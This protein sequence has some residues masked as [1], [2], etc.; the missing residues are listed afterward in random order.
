MEVGLEEV[1]TLANFLSLKDEG[2][3]EDLHYSDWEELA[4]SKRL[5]SLLSNR[6]VDREA[7]YMRSVFSLCK[8]ASENEV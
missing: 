8:T 6:S 3:V 2:E 7:K 5:R 1:R 4:T